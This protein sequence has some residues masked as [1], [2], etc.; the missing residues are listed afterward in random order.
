MRE[1]FKTYTKPTLIFFGILLIV[2][3]PVIFQGGEIFGIDIR[4]L[5]EGLINYVFKSLKSGNYP[6]ILMNFCSAT[7][8][9]PV[10]PSIFYPSMWFYFFF[11][12]NTAFIISILINYIIAFVGV[13]AVGQ[14]FKLN[15]YA[16][17]IGGLIFSV[18]GY[19]FE[20]QGQQTMVFANAWIPWLFLYANKIIDELSLKNIVFMFLISI[21]SISTGRMDYLYFTHLFI[22]SWFFLSLLLKKRSIKD[23]KLN[24]TFL[25]TTQLTSLLMMSF[26]LLPLFDYLQQSLRSDGVQ[27]ADS[28]KFAFDPVFF[29][30]FIFDEFYGNKFYASS[31]FNLISDP[32]L[33]GSFYIGIVSFILVIYSLIFLRRVKEAKIIFI[34]LIVFFLLAVGKYLNEDL[35]LYL[36]FHFPFLKN[37]RYPVKFISIVMFCISLLSM[38]SLDFIDKNL[39]KDD[40]KI[41]KII[42]IAVVLFS[43]MFL[44]MNYFDYGL[45]N[46]IPI[47]YDIKKNIEM[48]NT[49]P[50]YTSYN[51][52]FIFLLVF[53]LLS[54]LN[55]FKL[56]DRKFFILLITVIASTEIISVL[57]SNLL[58]LNK[59]FYSQKPTFVTTIEKN[60]G[61]KKLYRVFS[62]ISV[63]DKKIKN[64][65]PSAFV[66]TELKQFNSVFYNKNLDYDLKS[67]SGVYISHDKALNNILYFIQ[68]KDIFLSK[69]ASEYEYTQILKINAIK[70]VITDES[71]LFS[72]KYF[73]LL[74]SLPK[75]GINLW[76][77][78]DAEPIYTFKKESAVFKSKEAMFELFLKTSKYNIDFSKVVFL[79]DDNNYKKSTNDVKKE[80]SN[81]GY[82]NDVTLLD[83]NTSG[84]KLEVKNNES[85]YVVLAN[86]NYKNW[87]AYDNDKEIPILTA[88]AEQQ[89]L[90]IPPGQHTIRME[91]CPE[92]LYNGIKLSFLGIILMLGQCFFVYKLNRKNKS[93]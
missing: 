58:Y 35:Y 81:N 36:Y 40:N 62:N 8:F 77:V 69:Y 90:R 65:T 66:N 7:P 9:A 68:D 67:F 29:L 47:F 6:H 23:K 22:F 1:I 55:N 79:L 71:H 54:F 21:L 12:Y 44:Y 19:S 53:F 30:S 18:N 49:S 78:K 57:L 24:F 38:F 39:D 50:I 15:K 74:S 3:F 86:H 28:V 89:A 17:F 4:T 59:G 73:T 43:L 75:F 2:F 48:W 46:T 60:I 72:K 25:I 64:V 26:I 42:L 16:C 27:V 33:F 85:G 37:M 34:L 32:N 80:K 82:K 51:K 92:P 84:V 41:F 11:D 88:N 52:T 5:D 56:I 45:K 14:Y 83:E 20:S 87:K 76:E 93:I 61:N 91:Y 10:Y 13:Y 63:S 31:L 70:Y